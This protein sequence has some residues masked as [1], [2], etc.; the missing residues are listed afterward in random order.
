MAKR[1]EIQNYP[2]NDMWIFQMTYNIYKNIETN[3]DFDINKCSKESLIEAYNSY[4]N[5][6]EFN[7]MVDRY[8]NFLSL[9]EIAKKYTVCVNRA[10]QILQKAERK[11]NG[12]LPNFMAHTNH[13]YERLL[14]AYNTSEHISKA[15]QEELS[16]LKGVTPNDILDLHV[17][18]MPIQKLGRRD[19]S[20]RLYNSFV[21]GGYGDDTLIDISRMTEEEI[22]KIRGIGHKG[23]TELKE[24]FTKYDIDFDWV[25]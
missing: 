20:T 2:L 23:M 25:N 14:V 24:I 21:R 3:V 7:I 1:I 13:E 9:K 16:R 22:S 11:F 8:Y 15:Y 12:H 18:H 5:A 10:R 6:R 4:F 17:I 19:I